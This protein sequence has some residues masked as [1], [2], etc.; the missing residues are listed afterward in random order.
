[1]CSNV[2]HQ[3]HGG[4]V[5]EDQ[6]SGPLCVDDK[7]CTQPHVDDEE[8]EIA[9]VVVSNAVEHPGCTGRHGYLC[10]VGIK[11]FAH[12]YGSD[13]PFLEHICSMYGGE[14]VKILKGSTEEGKGWEGEMEG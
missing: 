11:W 6:D 13:G 14:Q 5:E 10:I 12:T 9:M 7:G 4:G 1:M 8:H 3:T 2:P